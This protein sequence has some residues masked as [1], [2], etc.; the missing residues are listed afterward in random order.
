MKKTTIIAKFMRI[1]F[2][3]QSIIHYVVNMWYFSQQITIVSQKKDTHSESLTF[4]KINLKFTVIKRKQ[5]H[6]HTFEFLNLSSTQFQKLA[7]FQN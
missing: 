5:L 6:S 4:N 1:F 3:L 7:T 2:L